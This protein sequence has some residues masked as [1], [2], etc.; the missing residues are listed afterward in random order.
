M[1]NFTEFEFKLTNGNWI[2]TC[3]DSTKVEAV[4]NRLAT[5]TKV[6]F[7]AQV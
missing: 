5:L 4:M 3:V 7:P 1:T 2:R 6:R